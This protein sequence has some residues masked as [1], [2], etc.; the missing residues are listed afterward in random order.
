MGSACLWRLSV[1]RLR[2]T[3]GHRRSW[4]ISSRAKLLEQLLNNLDA[5]LR[6]A[7]R[8]TARQ[9]GDADAAYVIDAVGFHALRLH[10]LI[11]ATPSPDIDRPP[12]R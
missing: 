3:T 1:D 4:R 6:E 11:T 2:A 8:R 5:Y 12:S 9:A 10:Q 7:L